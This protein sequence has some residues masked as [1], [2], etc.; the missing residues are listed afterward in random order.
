MR[1]R[2]DEERADQIAT[3]DPVE[4]FNSALGHRMK[5][6]AIH[7]GYFDVPL[8][9]CV[10]NCR[11]SGQLWQG[12]CIDGLELP[13]DF[14]FVLSLYPWEQYNIGPNTERVEVRMYD[15]LE[16][17]FEQVE[18]LADEVVK[19]LRGRQK[20]LVH[21]QAGLNRSGLLAATILKKL[22]YT[23][24]ED[25]EKLRLTRGTD[26]VLCNSTFEDHVRNS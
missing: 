6:R 15:S 19:R 4:D 23:G 14:D 24:D 17:G 10:G 22:G 8:I 5:G 18:E 13:D 12:G 25:V 9:S 16:Q 20:V 1:T 21:C 3:G 11:T 26:Q 7:G 2:E